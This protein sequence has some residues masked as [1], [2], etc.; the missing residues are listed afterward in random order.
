MNLRGSGCQSVILSV[1]GGELYCCVCVALFKAELNLR[2]V[3][4]VCFCHLPYL[5]PDRW[6][7]GG[8]I[9]I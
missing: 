5:G 9:P 7:Q 3:G 4:L 8:W 2:R 6:P 1:H